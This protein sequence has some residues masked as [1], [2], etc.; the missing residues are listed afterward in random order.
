MSHDDGIGKL[1]SEIG[2]RNVGRVAVVYAG[3]AWGLV[4]M[5]TVMAE[6]LEIPHWVN[7]F[8]VFLLV[9][10][11]PIVIGFS[12][13][14]EF[15]PEGFKRAAE[16]EQNAALSG[17]TARRL[18]IAI[19]AL[20][21]ALAGLYGG[22][23]FLPKPEHEVAEGPHAAET[24]TKVPAAEGVSIAV[25]PFLNLSR[26]PDQE[27]FSDG[28]TEEITSALAKVKGLRV[29]GR[30]SA[31]EFKGQNKD[32]RAI[33]QALGTANLLEGS[34]RKEGNQIRVTAQLIRADNGSHIWTENYDRELKSVFAIQDEISQAIA[35]ALQVPLGLKA[36][37]TL[38]TSQAIA[39]ESYQ[40]YLRAKALF[41]ARG[42]GQQPITKA[43]DLLEQ[44][45]AREPT[46]GPAWA[47][48][49][50]AYA[51]APQEANGYRGGAIE[52]FRRIADT[53]HSKAAAAG[54]RAI[55]LD[56]R[57]A[58]VYAGAANVLVFWGSFVE[59]EDFNRQALKLDPFNPDA[60]HGLS[61][62]LGG[63]GRIKEAVAMRQQLHLLEP[64]VPRFNGTTAGLLLVDGQTEAAL[65]V[66]KAQPSDYVGVQNQIANIYAAMGKY[67]EAAEA[68][69]RSPPG[70]Y[71][72]GVAEAA[73]KL[74]L[75]APAIAAPKDLPAVPIPEFIYLYVGA[76]ERY[77]EAIFG[78]LN[79]DLEAGYR[80]IPL[81]LF[82]NQTAW[83]RKAA[84][85]KQYVRK[86]GFVDYW[87]ARGW[88]DLCH[89]VGKDDFA[90]E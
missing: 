37:E 18:D 14:F 42:Y 86:A 68:I 55:E 31:F 79:R 38:V 19:I 74:L 69:L 81:Q 27:F 16:V 82:S 12:W 58:D 64:L 15:T 76:R 51:N 6:A 48:L 73:A 53:Y 65:A 3:A 39:P 36:G 4:H 77:L 84:Q 33:G 13:V 34:V 2:R 60:L 89:P 17:R 7:R 10:L 30:T 66:A 52:D 24:A 1:W 32:L 67:K 56:P 50:M 88:P 72:P 71:A 47:L 62:Q 54:R 83:V 57:N 70:A 78:R 22:E 61:Q 11:A 49:A 44:V 20:I 26:D 80:V 41:R 63:L 9:A 43:V 75:L 5:S 28:M 59:M 90:C 40:Q 35:G 45:V 21:V 23:R 8:L 87:R 46:Y 85:F 29:V 25:L